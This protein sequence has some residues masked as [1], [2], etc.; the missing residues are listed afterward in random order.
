MDKKFTAILLD[1]RSI[2]RY[3][4]AGNEL[5]SHVG[6]SYLVEQAFEKHL[7]ET[8]REV[9]GDKSIDNNAWKTAPDDITI[10]SDNV[11]CEIAYIGGGNALVLFKEAAQA[12]KVVENW[13]K[14]LLTAAPGLKTGAAIGEF[15]LNDSKISLEQLHRQLKQYQNSVF[16]NIALPETGLTLECA[17]TGDSGNIYSSINSNKSRYISSEAYAK[18]AAFDEA[19]NKLK[20][21]DNKLEKSADNKP[22]EQEPDIVREILAQ[23]YKFTNSIDSLGQPEG[24]NYI[25]IVHIDGNNMGEMFQKAGVEG[26]SAYRKLSTRVAGITQKAFAKLMESIAAEYPTYLQYKLPNGQRAFKLK[27]KTL[28][29][30]PII[31]GGDD[32]TFV[33][34]GRLGI[35][36]AR[37]FMHNMFEKGSVNKHGK[38]DNIIP[39][40]KIECCAGIAILPTK[41][42][43]FRGY[44]LAEQLCGAAKAKSR[45]TN[46]SWLD[47]AILHGEQAPTLEQIRAMEYSGVMGDMHFGPYQIDAGLE[48]ETSLDVLLHG[49]ELLQARLPNNKIK[50]LRFVLGKGEHELNR[51]LAQAKAIGQELPY[52]KAL[53][54]YQNTLWHKDPVTNKQKTPYVDMIE[55]MGFSLP[56]FKQQ[57]ENENGD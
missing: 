16:T 52:I 10:K 55:V 44:E 19:D 30:R 18:L 48:Q 38:A 49:A 35:E 40:L 53:Q 56:T 14:K 13:S 34:P 25:A 1:T 47:F 43:F 4:F 36:Y 5:R 8:L 39:D 46:S 42:P 33:C 22:A 3:I 6:A 54:S 20:V 50:E 31:I 23:G 2:Q 15:D 51:F 24:E 17:L 7:L 32:I 11:N 27:D 21:S 9:T 37:R 57:E 12:Q 41:Y 45:G 29:I 26:I 28:P